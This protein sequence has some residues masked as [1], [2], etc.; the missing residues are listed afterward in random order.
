MLEWLSFS[1]YLFKSRNYHLDFYWLIKCFDLLMINVFMC[2]K[3]KN[4]NMI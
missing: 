4:G 3:Y 1:G 2:L